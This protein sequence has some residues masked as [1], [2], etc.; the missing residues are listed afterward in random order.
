MPILEFPVA[1]SSLC[2]GPR[3]STP[4]TAF[5]NSVWSVNV[6]NTARPERY[7]SAA[8]CRSS[9]ALPT[10]GKPASHA[11]G[12]SRSG[13][14]RKI[15]HPVDGKGHPLAVVVTH[16]QVHDAQQAQPGAWAAELTP[17]RSERPMSVRAAFR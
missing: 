16:G 13:L 8:T 12:Q 15:H 6:T 2:D 11:I 9:K 3:R 17:H 1:L 14:T 4:P 7:T 10:R 5:T